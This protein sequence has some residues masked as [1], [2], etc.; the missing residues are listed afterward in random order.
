[1]WKWLSLVYSG[2]VANSME[3]ENGGGGGAE[4]LCSS[5]WCRSAWCVAPPASKHSQVPEVCPTQIS[6]CP[7]SPIPASGLLR[8]AG[9]G[10]LL[11]LRSPW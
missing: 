9:E 4:E 2:G 11:S 6:T 10:A 7:S 8:P 3:E 5:A 1:M